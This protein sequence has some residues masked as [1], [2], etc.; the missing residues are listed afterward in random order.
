M[1]MSLLR[2]MLPPTLD[3]L[4][5][6]SLSIAPDW[7]YC[8]AGNRS[9]ARM[10]K[11]VA[12]RDGA[13]EITN[14]IEVGMRK[15]VVSFVSALAFALFALPAIAAPEKK[16]S[17][18]MSP[19]SIPAATVTLN[20]TILNETPNGN[21][22]IN[23]LTLVA[24]AGLAI[25]NTAADPP[26]A[27][28]P[29]TIT[30]N[31]GS[32]S[33]S[34]MSPLKPRGS[35]VLTLKVSATAGNCDA[36]TWNAQ[37]WTG[38]S[39]AGDTFRQ[40]FPP[41][42]TA[43]PTT[44]VTGAYVLQF[45]SQPQNAVKGAVITGSAG[46]VSVQLST[47]CGIAT[48]FNGNVNLTGASGLSGASVN[49]V[50][51]TATFPALSINAAGIYA[52]VANAPAVG[53]TS[54][55]S[56][57]FTVYDGELKCEPGVPYTFNSF[58]P[59]VGNITQPGYAA[60][61]R[62]MYNKDGS[63]CVPVGYTFT[64]D[65]LN[66]NSVLLQWN[67]PSQP[68]AAFRYTVTWQPEYVDATTGMPNRVTRVAWYGPTGVLGA[69]VPGRACRSANL[70]SP[71]GALGNAIGAGDSVI[72]VMVSASVPGTPFPIVVDNERMI[73]TAVAGGSWTVVRGAGGTTAAVHAAATAVMTTP[74][75]LD[76]AGKE[77]RMC[78][79]EEGWIA[80][81]PGVP[82]CPL[83]PTPGAPATPPA[84][85]LY[86]TTVID[87]GDGFMSRDF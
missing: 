22:S 9:R 8:A 33:I 1:Q 18:A 55:P 63:P 59:G 75:P 38:S 4:P 32:I 51:G 70:P 85:V 73:V 20:A 44:T 72:P 79:A 53:A 21:S 14:R 68:A 27:T 64:N 76:G 66:T 67:V 74:L 62:G 12:R 71:L 36:R 37:A 34:N 19:S 42:T 83:P 86:S 24:P 25:A 30:F 39:F 10:G 50:G 82:G 29:G 57:S 40:L 47:A 58:P 11:G 84:C 69:L 65:I 77:M 23:S 54:A 49:A 56:A 7:R 17:V 3:A 41:E 52:L 28:W 26:T 35:F 60:G 87:I 45:V 15:T 61:Q 78:I 48:S 80:I 31:A 13:V 81:E 46:P 2:E 5:G 16:F 43:N 6:I